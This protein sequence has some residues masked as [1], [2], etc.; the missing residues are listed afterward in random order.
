MA[1]FTIHLVGIIFMAAFGTN[2]RP[3][4]IDRK[5]RQAFRTP[6]KGRGIF[7]TTLKT[8]HDRPNKKGVFSGSF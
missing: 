1:Y 7:M 5:R 3:L 6:R 8:Q 2:E 4:F